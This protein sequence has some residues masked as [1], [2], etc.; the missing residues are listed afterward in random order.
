M[1]LLLV[2]HGQSEG[3]AAGIVQG[4]MDFGLTELG[5]IQAQVTA[6]RLAREEVTRIV[7]SPLRRA[8]DTAHAIGAGAGVAIEF[9]DGLREYD[10]GAAS[11][12]TAAQIRERSP[13]VIEARRRGERI[14]YPG[15]EGR[16]SFHE[17]LHAVLGRVREREGGGTTVAVA[18]GGVVGAMCQIV[19]GL[20]PKHRGLFEA[21]NCSVTEIVLDRGG[22]LVISR[23]NDTCHLDGIVT[24]ID[25]G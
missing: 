22:R 15:E 13:E 8:A 2:R 19:V 17:R 20:G 24:R 11:G 14:P 25:R 4:S 1:R 23:H 18:H 6:E 9:D 10:I 7:S 3:N 5:L 16:E 12:L 21:A